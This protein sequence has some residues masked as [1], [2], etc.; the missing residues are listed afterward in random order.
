MAFKQGFK[1]TFILAARA[2]GPFLHRRASLSSLAK[3]DAAA[4]GVAHLKSVNLARLR[5]CAPE[6][7]EK[8]RTACEDE[9]F[10]H[11]DLRNV[12]NG[13]MLRDWA[14]IQS[15]MR[16][17]FNQHLDEKMK[18]YCGTVLHGY[19]LNIRRREHAQELIM[20]QGTPLSALTP[21]WRRARGMGTSR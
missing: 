20:R 14:S 7:A 21:D 18:Y 10:F 4:T 19:L 15:L 11:L 1:R 16:P 8:L 12:D 3:L 6:E 17:W 13:R 2:T 5:S 9:G